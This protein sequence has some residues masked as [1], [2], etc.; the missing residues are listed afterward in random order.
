MRKLFLMAGLV[1]CMSGLAHAA[2]GDK[3]QSFEVAGSYDY[4]RVNTTFN[5][6]SE[7]SGSGGGT[8]ATQTNLNLNG[9][10]A[11]VAYNPF[12]VLGL[13]ANFDGAYGTP[14][15]GGFPVTASVYSY[16]FGPRVNLRNASPFTPF[17]EGLFGGA[18]ANFSNA[19]LG[20]FSQTAFEGDFGGGVDINIGSHFALRPKGD[21]VL[22]TFGSRT[23]NNARVAVEVVYKFGS[24]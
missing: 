21:Y 18:H 15:V 11:E 19:D 5:V 8:T 17:V 10:N 20:S 4:V 9:W 2:C 24:K 22:T 7:G 13:V 23:Q 12:C 6:P 14:T 1:L 16:V 3:S